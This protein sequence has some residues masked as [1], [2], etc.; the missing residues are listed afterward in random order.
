MGKRIIQQARG[1]GSLRYRVK[2]TVIQI[3]DQYPSQFGRRRNGIKIDE[4]SRS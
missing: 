3:Q 2:K 1:H 4:L